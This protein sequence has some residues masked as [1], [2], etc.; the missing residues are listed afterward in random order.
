MNH[1]E[2]FH[3][4]EK[5]VVRTKPRFEQ[6]K[7]RVGSKIGSLDFPLCTLHLVAL[8]S[9]SAVIQQRF[10]VGNLATVVEVPKEGV[11][12]FGGSGESYPGPLLKLRVIHVV[13]RFVT[14]IAEE[15]D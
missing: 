9:G 15:L 11:A 12:I 14:F 6:F 3:I 5:L 4:G 8:N 7:V 2:V 13:D 1:W 10:E